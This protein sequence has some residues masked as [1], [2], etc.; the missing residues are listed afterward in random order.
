MT[1]ANTNRPPLAVRMRPRTLDEI[2][3]QRSIVA[4]GAPLTQ[5]VRNN[6]LGSLIL[7]GPPG[8]GKTSIAEA[9]ANE[10]H[11]SFQKINAVLS[12]VAEL[13]ELL[14]T[15]KF[16][17]EQPILFIDEIHRFNKS[18][19]DLLLP[20]VEAGTIQLIGATTHNPGFY[21]INPLLSR[22]RL[23][24]LEPLSPED[25]VTILRRAL[26]DET[27][28]LGTIQVPIED[29][30]LL[31]VAEQCNGDARKALNVLESVV[32][33]TPMGQKITPEDAAKYLFKQQLA[34]DADEDE[35]YN[36]ISAYIKSMRG[37][38]PD[39]A[40]YWLAVMLDGGEDP[41][42]IARRLVIFASEDIGLADSRALTV[43][44][45]CFDACERV[46]LPECR[47]NLA[48]ATVF[49]A[50]APKSN[51][52]YMALER[53]SSFIHKHGKEA[54]PVWLRDAH[55][56]AAERL[57]HGKFY[58][59]SHNFDQNISGQTYM[60]TPKSFYEPKAIGA[61]KALAEHFHD[62]QE[63]RAKRQKEAGY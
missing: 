37:C 21:V 30:T 28:G 52:A 44:N 43:T 9:I 12:N 22:C 51:S 49:C 41:R 50:L 2:V 17:R 34:Y 13:R 7:Y 42:V 16:T 38:D 32:L 56:K 26:Q 31:L 40:V 55:G 60:L 39:A 25:L 62:L 18:Q 14:K 59:Y 24:E 8:S 27:H 63:L 47:I 54:V 15:A 48:H 61:E 36:T 58:Q 19:Q 1:D 10:T 46:G 20:D 29:E 33:N 3:G 35:H 45:A 5:L 23:I 4:Q 6:A 53:A 11:K 57:M